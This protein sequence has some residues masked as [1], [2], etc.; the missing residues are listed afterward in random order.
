MT[1]EGALKDTSIIRL[2]PCDLKRLP[3][4]ATEAY[5]LSR[6]D[7]PSTL[8]DLSDAVALPLAE[9]RRVVQH[10][11]QLGAVSIDGVVR[12]VSVRL[13]RVPG[14]N[15]SLRVGPRGKTVRPGSKPS[16][17][18]KTVTPGA[19]SKMRLPAAQVEAAC[20]LPPD[21]EQRIRELDGR[22]PSL[23]DHE[24]LSLSSDAAPREIRRAYFALAAAYHPDKFYGKKLGPLAPVLQRVFLRITSAHE[25]LL[26]QAKRTGRRSMVP[27]T[28]L[29]LKPPAPEPKPVVIAKAPSAPP[30][31]RED[32]ARASDAAYRR[33]E[34]E[35]ANK[36]AKARA[37]VFAD[38]AQAAFQRGDMA[39]ASQHY[40]LAIQVHV[41]PVWLQQLQ[42]ARA[43]VDH[44]EAAKRGREAEAMLDWN[45][46]VESWEAAYGARP[47]A[48]AA[49]R[50]ANAL[51][52]SRLDVR[53]AVTLA[54]QASLDEPKDL[55][56]RVTLAE[57]LLV[58]GLV[59]RARTEINRVLESAPT[60]ERAKAIATRVRKAL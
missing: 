52:Q 8:E 10:L 31:S 34:S 1:R 59:T 47:T 58:A 33:I 9:T 23:A 35:K 42:V 49:E 32:Y 45:A 25:R 26:A 27:K 5:L 36:A 48:L 51:L 19:R 11:A 44:A 57:A 4:G 55:D 60:H 15:A 2:A 22:L 43:A 39:S 12:K 46:A 40:Q 20:E 21:I 54:Q 38:L 7:G 16:Q 6:L 41:D 18:R 14:K 29:S 37:Q 50:L 13:S 17:A 24:V 28:K 3:I 56:V 30:I 53:R